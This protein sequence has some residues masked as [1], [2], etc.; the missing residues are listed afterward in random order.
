MANTVQVKY[1]PEIDAY[2]LADEQGNEIEGSSIYPSYRE[3]RDAK[4]AYD[5]KKNLR[6]QPPP[7]DE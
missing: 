2:T 4:E 7:W 6:H 1:L 5:N 3:A